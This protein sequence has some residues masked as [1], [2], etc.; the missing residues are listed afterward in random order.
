MGKVKS[1]NTQ[2]ELAVRRL[3]HSLGYR[4]RLHVKK[5]PG[6]P[7]MVFAKKKKVIFVNGCFWHRHNCADGRRLPHARRKFWRA[8][9]EG[10]K[11]RDGYNMKMLKRMG[12][13]ALTIWTCE[14]DNSGSMKK[15]V[16]NFLGR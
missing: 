7:D 16:L 15:K 13:M 8:K 10:N 11:K 9:L 5:L 1:R 14:I 6:T 2:P 4:Y 3:V 12:W